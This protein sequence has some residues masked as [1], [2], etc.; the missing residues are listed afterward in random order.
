MGFTIRT[1]GDFSP[2]DSRDVVFTVSDDKDI[3]F[4]VRY[5]GTAASATVEVAAGGDI[6]L[7][8]GAV[9]S[10]AADTSVGLPTKNG[11]YDVSDALADTLGEIVDDINLSADWQ[12][13]IIDGLRSDSSNDSLLLLSATQAKVED[14]LKIKWDTDTVGFALTQLVAPE[15][16]RTSIQGYLVQG[17]V[18]A[19]FPFTGTRGEIKRLSGV[20]T[21]S[22]GTSTF[23]LYSDGQ[24]VA[25]TEVKFFSLAAGATTA[26]KEALDGDK[27]PAVGDWG[28]RLVARLKNSAAMATATLRGDG[29]LFRSLA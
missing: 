15:K 23:E 26:E 10:E 18:K 19:L 24:G 13:V 8:S 9:G 4:L 16:L 27:V 29:R 2:A 14:G 17:K 1:Y 25:A 3:A 22:S 7:K 11:V 12:A 20:S 21:Y 28:K 5:K 6:T